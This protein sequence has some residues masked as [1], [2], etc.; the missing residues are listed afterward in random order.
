MSGAASTTIPDSRAARLTSN[1]AARSPKSRTAH[2]PN[3]RLRLAVAIL[4]VLTMLNIAAMAVLHSL[5]VIA[6]PWDQPLSS[7]VAGAISE[8]TPGMTHEQ[9]MAALQA[10]ADRGTV[11]VQ[12]NARPVFASGSSEGNLY[13]INPATN[14]FNMQVVITLDDNGEVIYRSEE[15]KPN[16]FIDTD[17][18][19]RDLDAG[20]YPA[21]ALIT[22][23][24]PADP[25]RPINQAS[26][27]LVITV[28]S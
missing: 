18:L 20:I 25:S 8:G 11:S 16:H 26:A 1:G 14:A 28:E 10:E 19:L 27:S 12:I 22:C 9:A 5:G 7:G 13:I 23:V 2:S 24:D 6:L 3:R 21:T 4:A 15:L 17:V